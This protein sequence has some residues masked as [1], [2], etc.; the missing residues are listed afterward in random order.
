MDVILDL[1]KGV[2][3]PAALLYLVIKQ[4]V[5]PVTNK[6]I[7]FIDK[8]IAHMDNLTDSQVQIARS[9]EKMSDKMNDF[10]CHAREAV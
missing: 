9:M 7:E 3:L 10:R 4:I 2:G 5:I 1:I 6:H 8:A